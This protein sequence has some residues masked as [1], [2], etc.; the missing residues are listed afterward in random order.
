MGTTD[1]SKQ[2]LESHT[3]SIVKINYWIV[4]LIVSPKFT[5]SSRKLEISMSVALTASRQPTRAS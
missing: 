2:V 1:A 4:I 5:D 3:R